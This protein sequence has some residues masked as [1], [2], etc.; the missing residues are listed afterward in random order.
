LPS[1][2][3]QGLDPDYYKEETIMDVTNEES[4]IPMEDPPLPEFEE[5]RPI[6]K[7]EPEPIEKP[8]PGPIEQPEPEP[9]DKP[10]PSLD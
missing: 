2:F 7:P 8:E 3:C 9:I 1:R 4:P 6:Q 10:E 5:P